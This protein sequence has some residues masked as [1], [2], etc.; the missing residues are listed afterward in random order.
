M[1]LEQVKYNMY[2]IRWINTKWVFRREIATAYQQ[3]MQFLITWIITKLKTGKV[4]FIFEFGTG[5]TTMEDSSRA[6]I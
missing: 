2:A 3:D 4:L 5:T 1:Q 6:V